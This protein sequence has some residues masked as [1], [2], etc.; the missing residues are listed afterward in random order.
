MTALVRAFVALPTRPEAMSAL[1]A[2]QDAM[3]RRA[4][5]AG[6]AMRWTHPEQLHVTVKFLGDVTTNTLAEVTRLVHWHA[7]RTLPIHAR[8]TG[9]I[10]FGGPRRAG[11]I[12]LALDDESG[13]LSDLA[14]RLDDDAAPLG[15][16]R[17]KRAFRAHVTLARPK[18]RGNVTAVL[19]ASPLEP[20]SLELDELRLCESRPGSSGSSYAVLA[21]AAL[22]QS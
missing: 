21:R 5:E 14:R 9:L 15:V 17:E 11:A 4:A 22:G 18:E 12:V 3:R 13:S 19:G 2:L 8:A 6:L 7:A 16:E 10:A 1:G 20:L